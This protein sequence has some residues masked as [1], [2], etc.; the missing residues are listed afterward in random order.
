MSRDVPGTNKLASLVCFVKENIL[1]IPVY[2]IVF[3]AV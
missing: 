3:Y 1:V 2:Y